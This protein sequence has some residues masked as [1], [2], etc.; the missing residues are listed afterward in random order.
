MYTGQ[1]TWFSTSGSYLAF[2]T[3]DDTEVESYYYYYYE[4]KTDRD[5]LYPEILD[6]KYPK[7]KISSYKIK[8]IWKHAINVLSYRHNSEMTITYYI[9]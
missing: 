5:D 9:M 2:A 7:V 3:F 6:L 4:D 1:A 8:Q